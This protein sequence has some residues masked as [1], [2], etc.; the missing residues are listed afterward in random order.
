MTTLSSSELKRNTPS[1]VARR[2]RRGSALR[3]MGAGLL[4]AGSLSLAACGDGSTQTGTGG[5]GGGSG[6]SGTGGTGGT[7]AEP[8]ISGCAAAFI[9]ADGVCAPEV[10]NCPAG[11]IPK[12]DE[13]CRP[14]GIETCATEFLQSD[15]LCHPSMEECPEGTF[16]VPSRGCLPIDGDEGCGQGTWG[17]IAD[18][19]ANVYVDPTYA[20]SDSD[21]T[22][23]R[24]L[25][26]IAEALA[27]VPA[28][29]RVVLAAGTYGEP[30]PVSKSVEIVGRCP[31]LVKVTGTEQVIDQP[32]IVS[33]VGVAGP[34]SIRRIHV[35]GAGVGLRVS[36]AEAH[37]EE[38]WV[39]KAKSTAMIVGSGATVTLRRSVVENT[40][41]R[42]DATYGD[43]IEVLKG[44]KLTISES[45]VRY[46]H[47]WNIAAFHAGTTLIL[48]D[49]LSEEAREQVGDGYPGTGV[50]VSGG[51]QATLENVGLVGAQLAGL[52]VLDEGTAV[53]AHHLMMAKSSDWNY[54][55]GAVVDKG[56]E[57]SL[58]AS[59]AVDNNG[60]AVAVFAGEVTATGNLLARNGGMSGK[61]ANGYYVDGG[62]VVSAYD[63]IAGNQGMGIFA[64]HPGTLAEVSW[65]L[66]ASNREWA[67]KQRAGE[68][69]GVSLQ[70]KLVISDSAISDNHMAGL[71]VESGAEASMSRCLVEKTGV[72]AGSGLNGVGI[73]GRLG[74]KLTVQ[75]SLV[76]GNRG[77]GLALLGVTGVVDGSAVRGVVAGTVSMSPDGA[78]AADG[79][80]DGILVL[81][82]LQGSTVDVSGTVVEGCDRAGILYASAK[83]TIAGTHVSGN[84]YGLVTQG[85]PAPAIGP[86]DAFTGNSGGDTL[87]DASLPVP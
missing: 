10:A 4:L 80:G 63:V 13:G 62:H 18:D 49:S 45:T 8:G 81:G 17:S 43:G 55:V 19:V 51:A 67:P 34:V 29:G 3:T 6:G 86:G 1:A 53:N 14:V 37:F 71:A 61:Q 27:L 76:R 70:A 32:A 31:S 5:H 7:P 20:G 35:T 33:V 74:A 47:V 54:G 52:E 87:P 78:P 79:I 73:W 85:S 25:T 75:S 60:S 72:E 36:A 57:L 65:A 26:T 11:Q 40:H 15:G 41:P 9:G 38:V 46:N 58:T 68:G 83:G 24:P 23:A 2:S 59:A 39:E 42:D 56:A 82:G 69:L 16:A 22:K 50:L 12:L 84:R 64:V 30:I 77:A 28:G 66:I 48:E 44:S 21:G